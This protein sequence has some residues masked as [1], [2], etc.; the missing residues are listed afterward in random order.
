MD[1]VQHIRKKI[2]KGIYILYKTKD[3]LKYDTFL[4]LYYSFVYPYLIY[5]IEAWGASTKGNLISLLKTQKCIVCMIK[6]VPIKTETAPLFSELKMLPVFKI[7]MLKLAVLMFK[8]H[9]G[10]ATKAVDCLFTKVSNVHDRNTRQS[11]QYYVPFPCKEIV[12]KSLRYRATKIWHELY[13]I[14]DIHC[15]IT[16]FG[17]H[18]KSYLLDIGD[19]D[20]LD[21]FLL[22]LT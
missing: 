11:S 7:Y 14:S 19:L 21:Q 4:T 5:C 15:I 10:Q 18:L 2:S 1:H 12:R 8:Y 17:Y 13:G 3:Y 22:Y 16:S 6:S 9:H 20:G